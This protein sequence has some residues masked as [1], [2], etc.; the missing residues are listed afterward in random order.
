MTSLCSYTN[1]S[2]FLHSSLNPLILG[3]RV[4][5]LHGPRPGL[6]I[7]AQFFPFPAD[8]PLKLAGL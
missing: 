6:E 3:V 8:F 7:E 4:S 2:V 1:L 5:A